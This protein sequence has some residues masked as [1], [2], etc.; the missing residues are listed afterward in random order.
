MEGDGYKMISFLIW[1]NSQ[2]N[3]EILKHCDH[4]LIPRRAKKM[5]QRKCTFHMALESEFI[6]E[7]EKAKNTT[8]T[9][10]LGMEKHCVGGYKIECSKVIIIIII[11]LK[12]WLRRIVYIPQT[13]VAS[14][15]LQHKF[16]Y[17]RNITFFPFKSNHIWLKLPLHEAGKRFSN[18]TPVHTCPLPSKMGQHSR[19]TG[20]NWV[21]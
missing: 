4:L 12:I 11:P 13:Y 14:I 2:L 1:K 17:M 6:R 20:A 9:K 21:F 8:N 5:F 7:W 18:L 16:G 19:D 15:N 10:K 3:S